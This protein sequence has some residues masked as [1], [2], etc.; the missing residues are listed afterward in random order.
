MTAKPEVGEKHE[1]GREEMSIRWHG[2]GRH[3]VMERFW[4]STRD[5]I[6]WGS[7]DKTLG[8]WAEKTLKHVYYTCFNVFP[9]EARRSAVELLLLSFRS[10]RKIKKRMESIHTRSERGRVMASVV[11]A[12]LILI[13]HTYLIA[14]GRILT[15]PWVTSNMHCSILAIPFCR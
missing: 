8:T 14:F 5:V 6:K 12:P 4:V 13:K 3:T 15:F 1:A 9:V 7:V 10:K 2:Y 11:D